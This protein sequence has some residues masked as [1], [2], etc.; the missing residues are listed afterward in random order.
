[1]VLALKG[2]QTEDAE[3]IQVSFGVLSLSIV[4]AESESKARNIQTTQ[5]MTCTVFEQA[6]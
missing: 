2:L 3:P 4:P 5:F 1:M 6:S